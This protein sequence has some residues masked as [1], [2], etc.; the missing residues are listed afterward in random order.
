MG[1]KMDYLVNNMQSRMKSSSIGILTTIFKLFSGFILGLTFALIGQVMVNYGD[2]AFF[3]VIVVFAGVFMKI[4]KNW[5]FF[6]VLLF[7]LFCVL[8]GMLLRMY[9]L[10]A[11]GV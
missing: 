2:L 3:M 9:I 6:G 5:R 1:L 10:I 8:V 7:D 11:P 4:S